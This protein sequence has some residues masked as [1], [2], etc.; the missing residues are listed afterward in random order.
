[1]TKL[2]ELKGQQKVFLLHLNRAASCCRA[3][4]VP[5]TN[6]SID[7]YLDLW[8]DEKDQLTQGVELS[9]CKHCW[10]LENKGQRS[11]RQEPVIGNSNYI[12]IHIDNLCNQ[13]CSYCSPKFSSAWESSI[14]QYGNFVNVSKSSKDN[15]ALEI[16]NTNCDTEFW[17]DQL[18]TFL[19]RGPVGIRLLGG[20]PLMQRRNLQQ[21]LELNT[22]QI[23]DLTI[24]TNL[25][26]PNNKFLKWVLE[27]FPKE[28]LFFEI[29]LDTVPEHNA[30]PR[31]GFDRYKFEENLELLTQHNVDFSF[32]SV[33]SVLNVFSVHKFQTWLDKNNYRTIFS[34]LNNPDCLSSYYLPDQFKNLILKNPLPPAVSNILEYSPDSVD[35]KLFEQ[36]NYL[37]QYFQRSN[38]EITD[39]DLAMYWTWLEEKFK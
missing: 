15:L 12:E 17:I 21:L 5:L 8:A 23:T 14:Q 16:S 29:S 6:Q 28:K 27:T 33:V 38:T 39:H 4:S 3:E 22:D 36:Y 31:A 1:M 25:N 7:H 34:Q 10:N 32:L 13:M 37:K 20:E 11:Y 24:I 30:I 35:L 2:C 18:K 9:G 26:P 19:S